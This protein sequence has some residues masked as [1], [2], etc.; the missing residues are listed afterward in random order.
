MAYE[1]FARKYEGKTS[2]CHS[3]CVVCKILV[4]VFED[5][6]SLVVLKEMC[7]RPRH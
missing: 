2:L 4:N 6:S 1:D 7:E 5:Q 3:V